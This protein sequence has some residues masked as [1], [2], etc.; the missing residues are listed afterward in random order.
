M[1]A[2]NA[3]NLA[4]ARATI[5]VY[6]QA[7]SALIPLCHIAQAQDGWLTPEAMDHIAELVGVTPAEVYGT[8][9]FY[10][11]LHTEEVGRYLLGVCTNIACLLDGGYELLEHAEAKL[12]IRPGQTT[13]DGG[14]TL[15]ET[16]CLAHCDQ[17][18]CLQVNYR[19]FSR[20]SN[21]AFDSLVDDLAQGKPSHEVPAHGVLNRVDR[22][23]GL[24]ATPDEIRSQRQ[25]GRGATEGS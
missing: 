24:R 11:M 19:F 16:E 1:A 9:S 14:F 6:P 7:R 22:D 13:P 17:A 3:E 15:E 20:V 18:P 25:A 10:D 5:A 8:A 23:G 2:L 21:D 4:R 12:G